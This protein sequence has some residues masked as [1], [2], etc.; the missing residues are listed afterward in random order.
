M[1]VLYFNLR[2]DADDPVLGFAGRWVDAIAERVDRVTVV[3]MA[4]GRVVVPENVRVVSVGK[5][6]GLSE[7]A[8]V[9]QFYRWCSRILRTDP[10]DVIFSHMI[11]A[12]SILFAPLARWSGTP[13]VLWYTHGATPRDLRLAERLVDRCITSTSEG[14]RLKSR[15]LEVLQHGIDVKALKPAEG[16]D[17]NWR[18][19]AVG[20][21]SDRSGQT[22]ARMCRGGRPSPS[23]RA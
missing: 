4:A 14:F 15:R 9:I 5:E 10:P 23:G 18:R 2:M 16:H 6:K 17:A 21:R 20:R 22:S 12:F 7:P 8:R 13:S 3:T 19:T 1:H 11:P